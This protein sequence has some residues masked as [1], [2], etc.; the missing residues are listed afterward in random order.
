MTGYTLGQDVR[1]ALRVLRQSPVFTGVAAITLALGI[2]ANTAIFTLVDAI[3]L[4]WLPV[5]SPQ[6]LVVLARNPSQPTTNSNYPD[7]CY[8][9]DHS[10]SYAGLI[11]FWSGGVAAGTPRTL[12]P[13][14]AA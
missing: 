10:R 5:Q 9:R 14:L 13:R 3:L 6:E 11:A 8:L 7:Y 1:Y 4:R 2:G 12:P